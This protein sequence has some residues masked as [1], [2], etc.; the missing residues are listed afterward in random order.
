[1]CKL[2]KTLYGLEQSPREWHK[3]LTKG[4]GTL[5]LVGSTCDPGLWTT[6]SGPLAL[7]LLYVDD[8]LIA[9][10]Q[11][12][13]AIYLKTQILKLF[14]GRDLGQPTSYLNMSIVRDRQ[15]RT[16]KISQ[17]THIDKLLDEFDMQNCKPR[18]IPLSPGADLSARLPDEPLMA[19]PSR[20]GSGVGHLMYISCMSRPDIACAT[21]ALAKQNPNPTERH[22]TALKGVMA[23]LAGTKSLS[24]TFRG[25]NGLV[26][27]TDSDYAGCV[28]T[29]KS[30]TGF[31][32]TISGAAVSWSSKLQSVTAQS[33]AEAEY[34][35]AAAAAR[36][37]VWLKRLCADAGLKVPQGVPLLIDHQA[38]LAMAIQGTESSRT[39]HIAIPYHFLRDAV[40]REQ[41]NLFYVPTDK[42]T[43]DLYTKPLPELKFVYHRT[44]LGL[45]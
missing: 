10:K 14:K 29:R 28:N 7:V 26:G 19:N 21:S 35:A 4:L 18:S 17:P 44:N 22:Y 38:A 42:N 37:A 25:N 45:T 36:E 34:I 12:D 15:A 6:E 11:N 1:M 24:L 33:T 41:L 13:Q 3:V 20:F 39:K 9:C 16:L 2:V 32:F 31:V 23:Y 43:A 30:R 40:A 27:Y 8:I 5:G